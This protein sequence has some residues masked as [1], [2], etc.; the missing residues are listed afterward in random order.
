MLRGRN[1]FQTLLEVMHEKTDNLYKFQRGE[2]KDRID[3]ENP[4]LVV[5]SE[6]FLP[7]N[8]ENT[9]DFGI[10]NNQTINIFVLSWHH[11]VRV[12]IKKILR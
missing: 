1:L 7:Q 12:E 5:S 3:R 10:E 4:E 2:I 8:N 11:P 9:L 6:Y